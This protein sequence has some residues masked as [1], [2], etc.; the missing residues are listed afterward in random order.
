MCHAEHNQRHSFS[1]LLGFFTVAVAEQLSP[2]DLIDKYMIKAEL[3]RDAGKHKEALKVMK[4]SVLTLTKEDSLKFKLPDDFHFKYAL[5]A[6]SVDSFDVAKDSA[7]KYIKAKKEEKGQFYYDALRLLVEAEKQEKI[8]PV[9]FSDRFRADKHLVLAEQLYAAEYYVEAFSVM[10]DS[11]WQKRDNLTL[12][13]PDEF[14]FKYA[15]MALAADSIKV[16]LETLEEYLSKKEKGQ[17]YEDA[18]VLLVEIERQENI[19]PVGFLDRLMSPLVWFKGLL[20]WSMDIVTRF[21]VEALGFIICVAPFA[22][23]L[24][25]GIGRIPLEYKKY[26]KTISSILSIV[27]GGGLLLSFNYYTVYSSTNNV[28]KEHTTNRYIQQM[29]SPALKEMQKTIVDSMQVRE[30]RL[31]SKIKNLQNSVRDHSDRHLRLIKAEIAKP[32]R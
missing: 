9:S 1:V 12:I 20:Y 28:F 8:T 2:E 24:I 18:L 11:I 13:S 17:F 31:D 14:P 27:A 30:R 22:L 6:L 16:A 19:V 26:K 21:Y 32:G 7:K 5:V 25:W 3:L 29:D 23:L 4:D 10:R 15:E